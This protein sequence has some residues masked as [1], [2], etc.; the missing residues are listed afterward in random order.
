[1]NAKRPVE[2]WFLQ[3]FFIFEQSIVR[4]T[5]HLQFDICDKPLTAF[6]ALEGILSISFPSICVFV[7]IQKN[8]FSNQCFFLS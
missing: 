2:T 4:D 3:V 8:C 7:L 5:Q 1:M 6:G